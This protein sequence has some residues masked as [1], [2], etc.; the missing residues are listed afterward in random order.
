MTLST[1]R[2]RLEGVDLEALGAAG[3][4]I[5]EERPMTFK[6]LGQ[7]LL[8]RWPGRDPLALT[9]W[10]RAAVP[11]VQVPPRGLWRRSGPVAHTSM[12]AWL[13]APPPEPMSIETLVRRYLAAFG[14]AS[15]MDAQAWSGLTRLASVFEGLRPELATFLDERGRELFDLPDAPRPEPATLAPPRF[16]YD[17][18]N[19]FLS[20]ADRTRVIDALPVEKLALRDNISI[21]VFTHDGMAA[22]IWTIER[23]PGRDGTATLVITPLVSL[24]RA[25]RVAIA[26]EGEGLLRFLT[27]DAAGHAVRFVD[28]EWLPA[29]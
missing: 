29:V 28:L 10:V 15:V 27:P 11:L 5:V 8:V 17:F 26:E 24:S 3:R 21:S 7:R 16:M 4:E 2:K 12:E 18:D 6:E 13:G 14:P 1:F 25:D 23:A 9:M 20:H 19:L 22:G